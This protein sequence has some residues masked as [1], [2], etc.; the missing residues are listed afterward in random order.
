MLTSVPD[1][2]GDLGTFWLKGAICVISKVFLRFI[3]NEDKTAGSLEQVIFQETLF[4][5]IKP[6]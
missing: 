6:S 1:Q 2:P 4:D 3:P 5:E